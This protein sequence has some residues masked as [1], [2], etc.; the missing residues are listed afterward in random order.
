[1][2]RHPRI[3]VRAVTWNL[4]HGRDFPPDPSL[5]TL[6]SRLLRLTERNR[7]HAQVNRPLLREFGEVLARQEWDVALLQEAPPGWLDPLCAATGAAGVL[8]LTSRNRLEGLR[9]ALARLNPDLVASNEG[10][11]NQLLVRPPWRVAGSREYTLTRRPERRRM[12]FASLDGPGGRR[13]A[14]ANLHGATG[15]GPEASGQVIAAAERAL[16]WAGGVPL[17]FG[18]DLNLRPRRAPETYEHL[19]RRLGLSAPADRHAL[20]HLLTNGLRPLQAPRALPDGARE[21]PDGR[22]RVIRLSDHP[23]VAGGFEVE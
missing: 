6:R 4:F 9:A 8:T 15:H 10:G 17:V 20:D 22:G 13:L 14:V 23:L 1:M 12:L 21:V 16:D 3:V 18:G 7:T 5:F 2:T 11:S 19:E